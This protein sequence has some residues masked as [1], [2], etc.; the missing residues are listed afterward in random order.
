MLSQMRKHAGSWM[1]KVLLFAIVV[2]FSFW[3][4]GSY[5]SR[6]DTQVAEVNGEK[7]SFDLYRQ[8]YKNLLDQYRRVYGEQLNDDMLKA[9][10][11]KQQAI[12]QLIDR[13]LLLQEAQRLEISVS[14]KEVAESIRQYPAFQVNGVFDSNRYMRLLNQIRMS[15]EE[16]ESNQQQ[17]LRL[18]KVQS[19]VQD[20]VF[21]SDDEASQWYACI[22]PKSILTMSFFHPRAIKTSQPRMTPSRP[23]LNHTRRI[24]RLI[25]V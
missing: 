23:I 22:M 16:F 19:M 12:E 18:Q 20:G 7:I 17:S 21:V 5:R 3:G 10:N 25:P 24:T 6:Q 1:I 13:V 8:S 14:D 4:V 2:V 11:L 15:A 9:L